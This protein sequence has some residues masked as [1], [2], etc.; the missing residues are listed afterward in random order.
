MVS[1]RVDQALDSLDWKAK[2]GQMA[3]VDI[4]ALVDST[5]KELRQDLVDHYIG[6]LGIGSVLNCVQYDDGRPAW[7]LQ[8]YRKAIVSIQETA[9]KYKRPPVIWG[10]DSVHGANYIYGSVVTPQPLNLAATF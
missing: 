2:I 3:Q 6:E 4:N 8:D 7:Y 1:P 5:T 10:L 9:L